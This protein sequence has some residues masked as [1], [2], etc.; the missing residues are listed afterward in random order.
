[1]LF[2]LFPRLSVKKGIVLFKITPTASAASLFAMQ[3]R[4]IMEPLVYV[5]CY[6]QKSSQSR[7]CSS[8]PLWGEKVQ[9]K[10]GYTAHAENIESKLEIQECDMKSWLSH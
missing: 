6:S 5:I 4:S 8:L 2:L 1:M 9:V 10:Q 3:K 7:L